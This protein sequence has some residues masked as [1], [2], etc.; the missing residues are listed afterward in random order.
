MTEK[1]QTAAFIC[2]RETLDGAYPALMLG[3]NAVRLGM[4]AKLFYTFMGTNLLRPG[5]MA[6]A[7][8][9]MPGAMGAIPGMTAMAS[10]M[11]KGKIEKANVPPLEDML[12]MAQLEG[13]ELIACRMT[14][15]ML[16]L[17]QDD[18]LEG[19]VI[20]TAEEFLKYAKDCDISLF[21]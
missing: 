21:T 10:S 15:D 13:V 20:Q 12:E 18:F 2:S 3:I 17:S 19:V 9:H 16:E 6:K 5:H 14:T 7:K 11:M 1:Q 4:K 8:F